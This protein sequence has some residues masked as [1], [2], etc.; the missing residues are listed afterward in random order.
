MVIIAEI[1]ASATAQRQSNYRSHN[2]RTQPPRARS[3]RFGMAAWSAAVFLDARGRYNAGWEA[4]V[5]QRRTPRGAAC[6]F[7]P[8]FVEVSRSAADDSARSARLDESEVAVTV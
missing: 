3:L 7:W 4:S 8:G 2:G 5:S 6:V 1:P